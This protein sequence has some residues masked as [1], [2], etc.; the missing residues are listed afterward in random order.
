MIKYLLYLIVNVIT[1]LNGTNILLF[2]SINI[3]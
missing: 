1:A 2:T 3:F